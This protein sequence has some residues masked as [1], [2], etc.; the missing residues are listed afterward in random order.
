MTVEKRS[1]CFECEAYSSFYWSEDEDA[2]LCEW[3]GG[4]GED[5]DEDD[6]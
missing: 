6:Y 1:W 3:C 2:W 4:E 5:D